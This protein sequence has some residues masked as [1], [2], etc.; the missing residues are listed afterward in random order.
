METARCGGCPLRVLGEGW[1]ALGVV[2]CIRGYPGEGHKTARRCWPEDTF[3]LNKNVACLNV[4][5]RGRS[6]KLLTS[7]R[8]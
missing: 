5:V 1:D 4:P 8:N 6:R 2:K 3:S 7:K